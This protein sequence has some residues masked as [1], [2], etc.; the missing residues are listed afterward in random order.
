MQDKA[1]ATLT[2]AAAF[3]RESAYAG[4]ITQSQIDYMLVQ[5]YNTARFLR[6]NRITGPP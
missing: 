5:R 3:F 2:G 1:A 4:I 6:H